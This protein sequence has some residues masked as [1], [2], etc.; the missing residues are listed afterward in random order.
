MSKVP[1]HRLDIITGMDRGSCIAVAKI[2]ETSLGMPIDVTMR[3]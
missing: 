1:L 2:M 3:L